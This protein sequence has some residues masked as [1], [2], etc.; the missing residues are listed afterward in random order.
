MPARPNHNHESVPIF[1]SPESD[2]TT[3]DDLE[4]DGVTDVRVDCGCNR[5]S[6][7]TVFIPHRV[8]MEAIADPTID[9]KRLHLDPRIYA[10]TLVR[11][12]PGRPTRDFKPLHLHQVAATMRARRLIP[13]SPF[14]RNSAG[15]R[16]LDTYTD[17]MAKW[18]AV[19]EPAAASAALID[20]YA[21]LPKDERL[22]LTRAGI[23]TDLDTLEPDARA[24]VDAMIANGQARQHPAPT[25]SVDL[26]ALLG[27][28]SHVAVEE[29]PPLSFP[30][31][32][33]AGYNTKLTAADLVAWVNADPNVAS[34]RARYALEREH[35]RPGKGP[36]AVVLAAIEALTKP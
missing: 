19:A 2:M 31:D 25:A 21:A 29:R 12:E 11:K 1:Q 9:L 13:F 23:V 35:A 20:Q 36:R 18:A 8:V 32:V 7:E 3:A 5:Y 6:A 22:A 33:T 24:S 26:A 4:P 27:Q 16:M 14:T 10:T 15:L 17:W 30:Q 34:A 28:A